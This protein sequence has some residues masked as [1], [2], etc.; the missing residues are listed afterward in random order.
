MNNHTLGER[1]KCHR[2]RLNMTQEQLAE[3]IGVSAQAV[4]KW[5]HNQSCPDIT[6]LPELADLFGISIDELLGKNTTQKQVHQAELVNE[7]KEDSNGSFTWNW[8][9]G[10]KHSILFAVYIIL[11]GGLLLL[12]HLQSYDISW[13]SV[14]WTTFVAFVGISGL[15]GG[16]SVFSLTMTLAGVYFLLSEYDLFS[17][18]LSWGIVIP[19]V[20][21]LWGVSLLIDVFAG[22]KKHRSKMVHHKTNAM[23]EYSCTDG[24]LQCELSF[25]EYRVNATTELL[26]GGNV[27]TSFGS[28]AVDLSGCKAVTPDCTL[29]VENSLGSLTLLMPKRFLA[30]ID[31]ED[32]FT[33]SVDV[34]GSP[35]AQVD[36][37]IRICLDNSLGSF[38]LRYVDT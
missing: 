20:L 6:V 36:G 32:T 28:F 13:W 30:K 15:S 26:K 24:Y 7:E 37:S 5:E 3:R 29:H 16:F 10:K 27:E 19:A 11:V 23:R 8:E 31:N 25:G 34:E 14:V 22:K 9:P 1:I 4:S 2:K 21:L 38:T 17:F 18:K 12:N 35:D 33:A